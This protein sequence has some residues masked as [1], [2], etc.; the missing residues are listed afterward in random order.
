MG[1]GD[2]KMAAG[3]QGLERKSGF[4]AMVDKAQGIT[5]PLAPVLGLA[6]NVTGFFTG[7]A[8]AKTAEFRK[9]KEDEMAENRLSMLRNRMTSQDFAARRGAAAQD[10]AR[11]GSVRPFTSMLEGVSTLDA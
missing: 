6:K 7:I 11:M 2:F 8:D 5:E 1:F 3:D 10:A 9:R 4:S